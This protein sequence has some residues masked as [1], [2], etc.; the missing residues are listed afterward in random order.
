MV[1]VPP[2]GKY[3]RGRGRGG[4][5]IAGGVGV[6]GRMR[7]GIKRGVVGEESGAVIDIPLM[8]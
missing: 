7:G 1:K 5:L 8:C 3:G 2:R 6:V 4:N